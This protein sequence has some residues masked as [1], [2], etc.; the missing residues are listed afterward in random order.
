[1]YQD[2]PLPCSVLP[3]VMHAVH[4]A[5]LLPRL[6]FGLV[7]DAAYSAHT[8]SRMMKITRIETIPVSVPLK[9]GMSTKTAHGEH[10]VTEIVIIRVHT[11][12]GLVG[13]GE[14]TVAVRWTGETS[15]SCVSLI[16]TIIEPALVG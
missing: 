1:M 8:P 10:V 13:L 4:N 3:P 7:S 2:G 11:D 6:R 9:K 15:Q 12:E 5:G 14:A 16:E